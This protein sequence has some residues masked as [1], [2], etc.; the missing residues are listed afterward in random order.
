MVKMGNVWTKDERLG[1]Q[2]VT[3]EGHL[4]TIV[5]YNQ[6][7]DIVVEFEDGTRKNATYGQFQRNN[8]IYPR[9]SRIG[10]TVINNQGYECEIVEY[11]SSANL[12]VEFLDGTR[13][14]TQYRDFKEGAVL[15]PNYPTVC[16]VGIIGSYSNMCHT[17][18]YKTWSDMLVR[19]F[20]QKVKEKYPT[21]K[22][23]TCCE[24]WKQ[25][26]NF[27]EWI[28]AQ[29][30]LDIWKQMRR[31]CLDKDIAVKHNNIYSPQTCFLV[32]DYINKIFKTE[33]ANRGG[34]PL[35]ISKTKKRNGDL[36]YYIT[37]C[38]NGEKI[39]LGQ[40][41]DPIDGFYKYKEYKEKRIKEIALKSFQNQE[42]TRECYEAM[43]NYTI[44][45]TD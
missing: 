17:K 45:I 28:N 10:E 19:C 2:T 7:N 14:K 38:I 41:E 43:M 27:L 25:F 35:G 30:N 18:E 36:I 20:N 15:N 13:V 32:P 22:N 24:E 4:I 40:T 16:G 29:G 1:Q 9:P 12:T 11:K 31:G 6:V 44:D 39:F 37:C 26:G 3:K 42:V 8:I 23:V 34:A 33:V 21:Y 5:E